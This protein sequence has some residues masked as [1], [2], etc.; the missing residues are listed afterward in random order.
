MKLNSIVINCI[1]MN[2]WINKN[3]M[4]LQQNY[5]INYLKFKIWQFIQIMVLFVHKIKLNHV[6]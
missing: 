2:N 6:I 5:M 4:N 3:I 1:L